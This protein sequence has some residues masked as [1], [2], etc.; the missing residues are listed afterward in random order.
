M[1]RLL[2]STLGVNDYVACNYLFGNNKI[3]NMRFIQEAVIRN[4]C[5]D[6]DK[7]KNDRIFILCT[8]DAKKKNWFNDG[9][10]QNEQNVPVIGLRDRISTLLKESEFS[11]I[12]SDPDAMVAPIVEGNSEKQIWNIFQT[13]FELI[14]DGDEIYFDI[15]HAFRS[16]PMLA[17]VVL[18]YAK[19][20]RNN[21]TIKVISYGAFETLGPVNKVKELP[22]SERN[23][24][25]FDLTGF[26][27]LMD[28]TNA[29]KDFVELG[30]T[31]RLTSL[32]YTKVNPIL[33]ESK[34]NDPEAKGSKIVAKGI[35]EFVSYIA[36]NDLAAI[37]EFSKLP[38]F[39]N[40]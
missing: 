11:K 25:V 32:L 31:N 13:I 7:H 10:K 2:I 1:G 27:Q 15:T 21:I 16:L 14:A 18:Q 26:V 39:R 23:A 6:W 8:E 34:G 35:D 17:L 24:P 28:W 3:E 9:H 29:A 5:P 37:I 33:K 20:L 19:Q 40:V 36:K 12:N 4:Y 22:L 38:S 30:N